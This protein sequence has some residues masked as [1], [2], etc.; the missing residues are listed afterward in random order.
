MRVEDLMNTMEVGTKL[1]ELCRAGKN[2]EAYRTLYDE[3]IV[4]VEAAVTPGQSAEKRGIAAIAAKGK[5]WAENHEVHSA[6]VDGPWP[7]GNRFI[8][9]FDYDITMK[10]T[11]KR[12]N[13]QEAALYEVK[14][15]K[16]VREEFFYPVG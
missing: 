6:K 4:S 14:G 16:I 7:H 1:V 11:G 15:D 3:D 2:E 13:M 12:I 10:A 9:R 5:W 8:V